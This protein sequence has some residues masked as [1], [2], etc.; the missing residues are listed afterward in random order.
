MNVCRKVFRAA[1]RSAA[2]MNRPAKKCPGAG[3]YTRNSA[4]AILLRE[5]TRPSPASLEIL[6]KVSMHM[7][8]TW[9]MVLSFK[10]DV[11]SPA[12]PSPVSEHRE[13]DDH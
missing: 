5:R 3:F 13:S 6:T 11:M 2:G 7:T 12:K 4:L 9:P 10:G 8:S 1:M